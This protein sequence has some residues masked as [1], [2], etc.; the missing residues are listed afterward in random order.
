MNA[1]M[2]PEQNSTRPLTPVVKQA[3]AAAEKAKQEEQL[4]AGSL[5]TFAIKGFP[6]RPAKLFW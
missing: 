5:D 1:L 3:I 2:I 4:K 6:K